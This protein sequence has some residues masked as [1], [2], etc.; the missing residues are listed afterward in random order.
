MTPNGW[1]ARVRPL[2]VV[3]GPTGLLGSQMAAALAAARRDGWEILRGW[4]VPARPGRVVCSGAVRTPADARLA[5]RAAAGGAGLVVAASADPATVDRLVAELRRHG[6]VH[7][8]RDDAVAAPARL[9][10][11]ERAM[12]G[13]VAEGLTVAEAAAELGVGAGVA[14]QRLAAARR[15]AGVTSPSAAVAAALRART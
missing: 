4:S 12:L 5:L 13:M 9:T 15:H 2:V 8:R 14:R 11:P 7:H 6:A 10:E 1:V 3:E